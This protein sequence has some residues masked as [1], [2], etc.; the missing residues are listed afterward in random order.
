MR[1][2][3]RSTVF[4][5]YTGA[6]V[7]RVAVGSDLGRLHVL[8]L[9]LAVAG[10]AFPTRRLR[11]IFSRKSSVEL[12]D[13]HA[14]QRHVGQH[15]A[16]VDERQVLLEPEAGLELLR[17]DAASRRRVADARTVCAS[18]SAGGATNSPA[19]NVADRER[20]ADAQH[21]PA[22]LQRATCPTRASPCTRNWRRAATMANSVPISAATG[23]SS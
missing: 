2:D 22:D 14:D 10:E 13:A 8:E 6:V 4:H 18:R 11:T 23:K 7:T 3:G 5:M 19:R 20:N 15:G 16:D 21:R 1:I 12:V 9:P 17:D